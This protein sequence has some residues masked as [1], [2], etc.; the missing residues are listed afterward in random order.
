MGNF[1]KALF[2]TSFFSDQCDFFSPPPLICVL[3]ESRNTGA[4]TERQ[5][6]AEILNN[7][8]KTPP[9]PHPQSEKKKSQRKNKK[10][11]QKKSFSITFFYNSPILLLNKRKQSLGVHGITGWNVTTLDLKA[12]VFSPPAGRRQ[13]QLVNYCSC[14]DR[15]S[16]QHAGN[17]RGSR[18]AKSRKKRDGHQQPQ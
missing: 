6:R 10:H 2:K 1:K 13:R 15:S 11:G 12:V 7:A 4:R 3:C 9:R 8:T 17:E 5:I 18:E 16:G 14:T